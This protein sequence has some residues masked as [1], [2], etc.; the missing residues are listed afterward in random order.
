[1]HSKYTVHTFSDFIQLISFNRLLVF[2]IPWDFCI[3]D[4]VISVNSEFYFFTSL[5][6]DL[7]FLCLSPIVFSEP[8]LQLL[9]KRIEVA[10]ISILIFT[11]SYIQIIVAKI[12]LLW[13]Q[14]ENTCYKFILL[15]FAKNAPT[16]T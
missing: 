13:R 12:V 5:L 9:K 6:N 7:L 1:M 2:L 11:S 14:E 4:H 3:Q 16:T 15:C 8:N 10:R